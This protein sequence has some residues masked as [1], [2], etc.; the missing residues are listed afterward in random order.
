[1]TTTHI[2]T[3]HGLPLKVI[4]LGLSFNDLTVLGSM[5]ALAPF[6]NRLKELRAVD[7]EQAAARSCG[8]LTAYL[9]EEGLLHLDIAAYG[10]YTAQC[11]ELYDLLPG[12]LLKTQK[13]SRMLAPYGDYP[14][15]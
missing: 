2:A 4:K 8:A 7:P 6:F 10:V 9:D 13:D 14:K 1:V 11:K 15:E 3:Q 12:R 5:Q